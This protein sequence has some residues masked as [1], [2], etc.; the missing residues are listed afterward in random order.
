MKYVLVIIVLLTAQPLQASLYDS[1]DDP[2]TTH[3]HQGDM[4]DRD[5]CAL[6]PAATSDSCD[7]MSCCGTITTPVVA[8]GTNVIP[9]FFAANSRQ[10]LPDSGALFNKFHSPPFR[11]PIS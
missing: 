5:C 3:T 9:I 2:G 10:C 7:S 1:C 8:M 4:N 11:P 6:D